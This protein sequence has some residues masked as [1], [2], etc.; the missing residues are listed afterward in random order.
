ML[1]P[2][3]IFDE[4]IQRHRRRKLN[5]LALLEIAESEATRRLR[6]VACVPRRT[7]EHS[8]GHLLC[9]KL[10]RLAE[11]TRLDASHA[12][13]SR[14][15]EPVGPGTDYGYISR[16]T[17]GTYSAYGPWKGNGHKPHRSNCQIRCYS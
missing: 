11:H 5:V 7:K 10:H 1:K 12:Q 15:G 16:E 13:V 8:G 6:D 9:P 4:T 17:H 2:T 3:S 14:R